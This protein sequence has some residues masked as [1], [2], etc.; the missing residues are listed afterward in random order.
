[1]GQDTSAAP[2]ATG[3]PKGMRTD[4]GQ[5]FK[6]E[7]YRPNDFSIPQTG[8]TFRLSPDATRVT[9]VLTI[10]RRDGAAAS[11][12]LVLDGDGL[13]LKRIAIDGRELAPAEYLATPD[14]LTILR[15]PPRF[16][17]LRETEIAPASKEALMGLY[18]SSNVYCTQCEAEVFRRITYFLDR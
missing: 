12:S 16:Q 3:K 7:D 2:I 9:G 14:Q 18:R 15:P 13:V 4:T 5:V 10:E 11:T 8:L 6:L 1:M 17:L